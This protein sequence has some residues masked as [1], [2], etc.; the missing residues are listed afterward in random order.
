MTFISLQFL[1]V[2]LPLA[3]LAM[4]LIG[5]FNAPKI[6]G[7]AMVVISIVFY[8]GFGWP[9]LLVLCSSTVGSFL[10]ARVIASSKRPLPAL[11]LGVVANLLLLGVFKYLGDI[12]P[13]TAP[14]AASI[15]TVVGI[16]Y[17]TFQQVGYLLQ[18]HS[19]RVQPLAF[20]DYVQFVIFFPTL[21]SGPIPRAAELA[22]SYRRP[23]RISL[24]GLQVGLTMI[25]IGI[26]KKVLIADQLAPA[27]DAVFAGAISP[28]PAEAWAG[29]LA[30]TFQV[31]F[32]FSGY[33]DI[34]IG[35]ARIFGIVL[36]VNF[37]SPLRATSIQDFWRR[38]HMTMTRFFSD[39]VY[40][41]LAVA[42]T[43]RAMQNR[44]GKVWTFALSVA[45]P[46]IFTFVLVG[47]WHDAGVNFLLFGLLHGIGL[48]AYQWRA[49]ARRKRWPPL[50]GWGANFLFLVVTLVLFRAPDFD[51]VLKVWSAMA[52]FG[53]LG[54]PFWAVTW[55]TWSV[56]AAM[57]AAI[58]V[59]M[60][61]P[62]TYEFMSDYA[63]GL[64][65]SVPVIST[66][67]SCWFRWRPNVVWALI[68]GL[69]GGA[70]FIWA[71]RG[72]IT[73]FA[74]VRF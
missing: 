56:T 3:I 28:T 45:L 49:T 46:T 20:V 65:S 14:G 50:M 1:L 44:L 10:L 61:L 67:T 62:S 23:Q 41:P 16:S 52:G 47:F 33:T 39:F 72:E 17:F 9:S 5:R 60:A 68:F 63:P 70:C 38:W 12:A 15:I 22:E 8:A 30:F 11:A 74:Y 26:A 51:T 18:V 31:Y 59:T 43:R 73:S 19:G 34:A 64:K 27:V 6:T 69:L 71:L 4:A 55:S 66:L 2:F 21:I 37:L 42:L 29:A 24:L 32:D 25:C 13:G 48:T 54:S 36:P 58:A 53:P 35:C 57:L 7:A 40:A